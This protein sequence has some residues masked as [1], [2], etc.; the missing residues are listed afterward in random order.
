MIVAKRPT[1]TRSRATPTKVSGSVAR[2][3]KMRDVTTR[4]R[5]S[6][7]A[8]P[9]TTHRKI[10]FIPSATT[11]CRISEWVALGA[12]HSD[13][14]QMVVA[15]GMKPIFL[16]V[17]I[18]LAAALAL[19]RVVTSLIFGVRAT[20]PLTFVGVALLLVAVGLFATIL[21]AY[22]ATRVEPVRMLR[23]E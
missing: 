6:A 5:A 11:I 14:L 8:R 2:T 15:D 9:M 19:S 20:D 21:P 23:E 13:I 22:R 1:A 12:T 10:G 17:V 4:L 7:A 16:G 18:G 3:P